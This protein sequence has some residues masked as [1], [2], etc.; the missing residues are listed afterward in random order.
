MRYAS[1][2]YAPWFIKEIIA[3]LEGGVSRQDIL[4]NYAI[5]PGTLDE[6]VRNHAS[7]EY[8]NKRKI[9]TVQLRDSVV[10]A[11]VAGRMTIEEAQASCNIKARKTIRIWIRD[12]QERENIDLAATNL[13]GLGRKKSTFRATTGQEQIKVLQQQ[14]ADEK[15]KVAALNTLM[16]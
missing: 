15:L 10:R 2:N 13:S 4:L 16:T 9:P 7:A 11:I 14:L 12:Y 6:W 5:S 1:G 8:R 3:R